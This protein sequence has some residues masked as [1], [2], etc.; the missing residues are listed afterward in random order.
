MLHVNNDT[1]KR[2]TMFPVLFTDSKKNKTSWDCLV[3]MG[4]T[5]SC[6]NYDTYV[7]LGES[8]LRHKHVPTVTAADGGNLGAVGVTTLKIQLGDKLV[9]QDFIV[10]THLKCNIILGIDFTRTNCAG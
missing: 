4:A 5:K 6:I 9:Q 10:C 3:D 2:G 7:K 1:Q 8:K